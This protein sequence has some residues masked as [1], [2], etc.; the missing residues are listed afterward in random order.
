M[1]VVKWGGR[2]KQFNIGAATLSIWLLILYFHDEKYQLPNKP[3][4]LSFKI[5]SL[6]SYK[7]LKAVMIVK[8]K[9]Y[10]RD[11]NN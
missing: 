7:S 5:S 11:S 2:E 6:F 10:L 3:E 4:R 1:I 8:H 9:L